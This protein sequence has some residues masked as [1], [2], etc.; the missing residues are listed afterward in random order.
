MIERRG[1]RKHVRHVGD[2]AG[3]PIRDVVIKCGSGSK[4]ELHVARHARGRPTG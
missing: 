3:I 2:A 4:H 1:P